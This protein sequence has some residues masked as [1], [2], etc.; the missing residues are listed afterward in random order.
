[1]IAAAQSETE[2]AKAFRIISFSR[3]GKKAGN[4]STGALAQK[5]LR[6][7]IDFDT[8]PGLA[9]RA[10]LFRPVD[11]AWQINAAIH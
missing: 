11:R 2:I 3:A 4:C 8:T 9:V 10:D 7:D 1:M 5:E 6:E